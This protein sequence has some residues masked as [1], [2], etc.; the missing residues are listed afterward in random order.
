MTLS[1]IKAVGFDLDQTLYQETL[2]TR[3]LVRTEIYCFMAETMS[4]PV[5]EAKQKFEQ[6]YAQFDAGG[7][8]LESL[9]ISEGSE[10]LRDCVV[11]ADVSRLLKPDTQLEQMMDRISKDYF[12]F[13]ITESRRD[14]AI[15]KLHAL[16]L[17]PSMFKFTSY[18]DTSSERKHTG[19]IYPLISNLN[20]FKPEEHLYVGDKLND[21]ILPAKR[22]GLKTVLVGS[23]SSE[24]DYSIS[25][26]H[27]LES[28]LYGR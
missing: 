25:N 8:A 5:S 23:N 9:G 24:A 12:T 10:R 3:A 20:G 1:H 4:I 17:C 16:G 15:K 18:W 22:V 19:T 26:I 6:A 7:R 2:E 14:D 28:L 21:D 11:K 27:E 13:L